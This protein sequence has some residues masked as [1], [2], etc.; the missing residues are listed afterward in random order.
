M[1]LASREVAGSIPFELVENGY[2]NPVGGQVYIPP[3]CQI[4]IAFWSFPEQEEDIRLYS[5]LANGS[6]DEFIKGN[7]TFHSNKQTLGFF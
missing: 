4:R 1:E 7:F 2:I 5:V 6:A 3:D